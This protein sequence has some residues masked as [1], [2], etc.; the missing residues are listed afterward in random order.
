MYEIK[1]DIFEGSL[2]LLVYLVQKQELALAQISIASIADQYIQYLNRTGVENLSNTGDFLVM[3]SRLMW[4]KVRELLQDEK[5]EEDLELSFDKQQILQQV[6][7]H[8]IF[9]EISEYFRQKELENIGSFYRGSRERLAFEKN[10]D[11]LDK[12]VD[13]F[14]LLCSFV[15]LVHSQKE[16]IVYEVSIDDITIETQIQRLRQFLLTQTIFQLSFFC[17]RDRRHIFL[18][19]TFMAVLELVKLGE[20]GILQNQFCGEIKVYK[21]EPRIVSE[22]EKPE[23]EWEDENLEKNVLRQLKEA[24]N[25]REPT[26]LEKLLQNAEQELESHQNLFLV[27]EK[28]PLQLLDI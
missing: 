20:L 3:A 27:L 13:T 4:L 22:I 18:V 1:I 25:Q 7:D 9:K 23:L 10:L 26:E 16:K 2:D 14:D 28:T 21:N 15:K 5:N 17:E 24:S 11:V 19:T 6:I 12:N 8:Q